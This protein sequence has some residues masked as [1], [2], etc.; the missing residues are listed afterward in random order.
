MEILVA[1]KTLFIELGFGNFFGGFSKILR[2]RMQ[3]SK[4]L[5]SIVSTLTKFFEN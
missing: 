1:I 5:Y 2:F 4:Y 3:R